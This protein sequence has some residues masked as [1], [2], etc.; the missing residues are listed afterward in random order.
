MHYARAGRAAAHDDLIFGVCLQVKVQTSPHT[1]VT[2][3]VEPGTMVLLASDS[4]V[5]VTLTYATTD[6]LLRALAWWR[7]AT[8]ATADH[9][10]LYRHAAAADAALVLTEVHNETGEPLQMWMDLGNQTRVAD[11]ATGQQRVMQPLV[12]A[13]PRAQG[14]SAAPHPP[15]MLLCVTLQALQLQVCTA[16]ACAQ[17]R[18]SCLLCHIVPVCLLRLAA[19]SALPFCISQQSVKVQ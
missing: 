9:S 3:G 5:Q 13:T 11:V 19:T 7:N 12:R 8:S 1:Q 2:D 4:C 16:T 17:H 6:S 15:A 18:P 10:A 14:A